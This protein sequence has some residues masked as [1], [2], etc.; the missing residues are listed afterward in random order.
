MT[1]IAREAIAGLDDVACDP[2]WTEAREHALSRASAEKLAKASH[3]LGI[4][5]LREVGVIETATKDVHELV[6]YADRNAARLAKLR[7][8]LFG[9]VDAGGAAQQQTPAQEAR[10]PELDKLAAALTKLRDR[11]SAIDAHI[12]HLERL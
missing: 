6:Q 3:D 1:A 9:D 7:A 11:L 4:C 5:E 2:S 8:R 10:E 12:T